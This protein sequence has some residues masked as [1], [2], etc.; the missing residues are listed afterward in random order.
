[1]VSEDLAV[2][3]GLHLPGGGLG[4]LDGQPEGAGPD[5]LGPHGQ[6][7][8]DLAAGAD[9]AGGQDGEGGD[10]VDDLGPEHEGADL[11]GV[12]AALGALADDEVEAGLLVVQRMLDRAGQGA[13]EAA[14]GL[15]L[16][17]D[18]GRGGA[19]RV[20]DEADLVVAEG[21]RQQGLAGGLGPAHHPRALLVGRG[22]GDAVLLEDAAGEAAV[23]VGDHGGELGLELHRVELAHAL[24]LAGD[25]DVDAVGG[26]G[27]V[28]VQPVE[29]DLE[30]LGGEADGAE[31]TEAAGVGDGRHHVAAVG[32]G[33]DGELDAEAF[34]D[35]GAHVCLLS[36]SVGV[37]EMWCGGSVGG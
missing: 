25:D 12:A 13:D 20:G 22:L 16:G 9:A 29:L 10:G 6:S 17:D 2:E 30:L 11:T 14:R 33:E 8:H 27:A 15:D 37:S 32:E 18:V 5:A 3:E 1:M 21:G 19:E 31:D 34:G 4:L 36:G 7:G 28:L 26:V 24:V 35:L 23:V